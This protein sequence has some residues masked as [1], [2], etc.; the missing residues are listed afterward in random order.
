MESEYLDFG[1]IGHLLAVTA[2]VSLTSLGLIF[3]I[4]H[5]RGLDP[6]GLLIIFKIFPNLKMDDSV[7]L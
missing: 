5:I 3:F 2:V 7:A 1:M 4:Y 6:G